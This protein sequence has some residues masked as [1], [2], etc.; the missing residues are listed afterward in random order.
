MNENEMAQLRFQQVYNAFV[1]RLEKIETEVY[2]AK[3]LLAELRGWHH[4]CL[5]ANTTTTGVND[6]RRTNPTN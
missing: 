6:A 5:E 1:E 2:I 3:K 4:N